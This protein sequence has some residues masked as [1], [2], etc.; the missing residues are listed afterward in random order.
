MPLPAA[1]VSWMVCPLGRGKAALRKGRQ[2][3]E[4]GPVGDPPLFSGPKSCFTCTQHPAPARSP[5]PKCMPCFSTISLAAC[6]KEG[7][8]LA[9]AACLVLPPWLGCPS[10]KQTPRQ[11]ST[12]KSC[13]QNRASMR[14]PFSRCA[15]RNW[16][17]VAGRS[18]QT[19]LGRKRGDHPSWQ[20]EE[21]VLMKQVALVL[22]GF[23]QHRNAASQR[24][25]LWRAR[26]PCLLLLLFDKP[27][28]I[29]SAGG[30]AQVNYV[31]IFFH[32]HCP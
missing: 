7:G 27:A 20:A 26:G 8:E 32:P 19:A 23:P 28:V 29:L 5:Q 4:E 3:Q 30:L 2:R 17:A 15:R 11:D 6:G 24:P 13:Q 16:L 14:A 1:P 31:I 12:G 9:E 18:P 25:G 10:P 21:L 22:H